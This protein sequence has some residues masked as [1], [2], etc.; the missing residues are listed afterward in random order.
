MYRVYLRG[1]DLRVTEKTDTGDR[2]AAL[3]AFEEMVDRTDL[4]GSPMLAVLTMRGQPLAHHS[5]QM[6]P[7]G[8]PQDPGKFWRGKLDD[9]T[10]PP[11]AG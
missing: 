5:F 7:S 8:H 2:V 4:D 9:I 1:P 6:T 10:W 11:M 3:A